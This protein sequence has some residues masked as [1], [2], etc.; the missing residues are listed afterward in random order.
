MN[1][2][3]F[4][5]TWTGKWMIFGFDA[6]TC[7]PAMMSVLAESRRL[8][9]SG[10]SPSGGNVAKYL[11]TFVILLSSASVINAN[12]DTMIVRTLLHGLYWNGL[13]AFNL[14]FQRYLNATTYPSGSSPTQ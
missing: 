9:L 8:A 3:L 13:A 7:D 1:V 11:Y 4:G 2:P 14:K 10:L 5:L 6:Q 12:L